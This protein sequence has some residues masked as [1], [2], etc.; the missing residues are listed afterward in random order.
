[1]EVT[2]IANFNKLS[3]QGKVLKVMR[4]SSYVCP[5]PKTKTFNSHFYLVEGMY[6]LVSTNVSNGCTTIKAL[7]F[8]ELSDVADAAVNIN[9]LWKK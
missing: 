7:E 2:R 1:M 3:T 8:E 6:I 9:D 5:L 4:N